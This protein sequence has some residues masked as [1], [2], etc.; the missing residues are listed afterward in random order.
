MNDWQKMVR[1]FNVKFGATVGDTP[2]I[3]DPELRAALI[4]EEAKETIDA[5]RAGDLVEA[6]DGICDL[7]YVAV[8]AAVA[9]GVN[10]EPFMAEVH[11]SN[12]AKEGGATRPDGKVLKPS[13]W[14]PPQ[15]AELIKYATPM[16]C[17][18]RILHSS[19]EWHEVSG[20]V[21]GGVLGV[22]ENINSV[23]KDYDPVWT[24]THVPTGLA[25][26]HTQD[27]DDAIRIGHTLALT[28]PDAW[29]SGDREVVASGTPPHLRD[30][31]RRCSGE[32]RYVPLTETAAA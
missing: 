8:G 31:L 15:I 14:Q 22:H 20:Q 4:E 19:G 5:I 2:A 6:I 7:I 21:F 11:R 3:R 16:T 17:Q 9:W 12:M 25:L 1:D 27:R 29:R 26:V 10:L 28:M 18:I 23:G 13:G 32:Y 24:L 30:W